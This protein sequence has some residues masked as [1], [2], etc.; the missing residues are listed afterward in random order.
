MLY[1]SSSLS[2]ACLEV[3]VHVKEPRLP[4]DYAFVRISFPGRLLGRISASGLIEPQACQKFGADW[5]RSGRKTVIR[6]PSA[7]IRREYNFLIN[8]QHPTLSE[9]T[10]SEPEPFHFDPRLLKLGPVP[11]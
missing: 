1:A 3:L 11:L 9:L 4:I 2:L 7:I 6:V 10:F 5:V 8:P